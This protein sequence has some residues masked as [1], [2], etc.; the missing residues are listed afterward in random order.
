V[1]LWFSSLWLAGVSVGGQISVPDAM[2]SVRPFPLIE[3]PLERL[4]AGVFWPWSSSASGL[5][6]IA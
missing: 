3:T 2:E 1:I 4:C 6:N 5:H